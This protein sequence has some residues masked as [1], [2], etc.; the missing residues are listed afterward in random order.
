MRQLLTAVVLCASVVVLSADKIKVKA[1]PDP[2]FDFATVKTWA[3]DANPG[4]VIM[5][6][7][8]SDDPA[9]LK[10]RI[11]PLIQKHVTAEM[12]K[13]GLTAAP[14]AVAHVFLHYY[15]LV[16]IASSGQHM[17]QFLPAVPYWG[18]PGF[19]AGAATSLSV[20]TKGSLVLDAM[21]PGTVGERK[22]VWRGIAESTVA[23]TDAPAVREARIRDAAAALVQRF[24]LKKKK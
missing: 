20:A 19:T 9:A 16:T 14:D 15:V 10:A 5:A 21:L 22:V 17:G 13:K 2:L 1:E 11:E 24:P 3:W 12:A 8:P 23:D 4:E 18:L 6:R 7:T